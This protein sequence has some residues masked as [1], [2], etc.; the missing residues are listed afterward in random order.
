MISTI[1][2]ANKFVEV[3]RKGKSD[4]RHI[5]TTVRQPQCVQR[6]NTYMNGVDKSDQLYG[7]I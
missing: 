3:E 1:D 6:Y 5:K 4:E 2:Q 7:E